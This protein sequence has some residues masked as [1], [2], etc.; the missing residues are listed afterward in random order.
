MTKQ[1]LTEYQKRRLVQKPKCSI[2]SQNIWDN[3]KIILIKEKVG[4]TRKYSFLHERCLHGKEE[5]E[6]A[7]KTA[8]RK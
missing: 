6:K 4:K 5:Q 8:V 3:D 7:T 2:C 1:N